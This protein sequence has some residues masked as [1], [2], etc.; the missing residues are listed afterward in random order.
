M[1]TRKILLA[2]L[3]L[4]GCQKTVSSPT[5]SVTS[6]SPD[7]V[8]NALSTAVV[9]SGASFDP[10]PVKTLAGAQDVRVPDASLVGAAT[11]DLTNEVWVASTTLQAT[12][13]VGA[14]PGTYD[15]RVTNP[16]GASGSGKALMLIVPPPTLRALSAVP[17]GIAPQSGHASVDVAVMISGQFFRPGIAVSLDTTKGATTTNTAQPTA[18]RV[19]SVSSD[20]TMINATVLTNTAPPGGPYDLIVKNN[21]GCSATLL[22]AYTSLAGGAVADFSINPPF[23]WDGEDTPVDITIGPGTLTPAGAQ[24]FAATP[25][26]EIDIR[27]PSDVPNMHMYVKL[28]RVAFLNDHALHALVPSKTTPIPDGIYDVRVTNPGG[29]SNTHVAAFRVVAEKVPTISTAE[30]SNRTTQDQ[31]DL[32]MCGDGFG[33]ES[34]PNAQA[35]TV[36][37]YATTDATKTPQA[38]TVTS[39]GSVT[40]LTY[41]GNNASATLVTNAAGVPGCTFGERQQL[42]IKGFLIGAT[43]EYALRLSKRFG[44]A[45]PTN[46]IYSDFLVLSVSSPSANPNNTVVGTSLATARR[47]LAVVEATTDLGSR[48][49]YAIGGDSYGDN[50]AY[51]VGHAPLASYEVAPI[52]PT[53]ALGAWT[54]LGTVGRPQGALGGATAVGRFAPAAVSAR[55]YNSS[56]KK[57]NTYVYV[58]GGDLGGGAPDAAIQR[59]LVLSER[60]T[61][62]LADPT[63]GGAGNLSA[64]TWYYKVSAI[65]P[66]SDPD[67]PDGETLPS[68]EAVV[69]IAPLTTAHTAQLSW[70]GIA[71]AVSYNIYRS[72]A[73]DAV[74]GSEVLIR[75]VSA[76]SA[77]CSGATPPVCQI[78]EPGAPPAASAQKPLPVGALGNFVDPTAGHTKPSARWG[79]RALAL[80]RSSDGLPQFYVLGGASAAPAVLGDIQSATAAE[81]GTLGDFVAGANALPTARFLFGA[82]IATTAT[83]PVL[84]TTNG[85]AENGP[86]I[87]ASFGATTVT[88]SAKTDDIDCIR[89]AASDGSFVTDIT[90]PSPGNWTAVW[91][92]STES[93]KGRIGHAA[94]TAGNQLVFVGGGQPASATVVTPIDLIN[95]IFFKVTPS[96]FGSLQASGGVTLSQ[97]R[98]LADAT[99]VGAN[100]YV[101][102]GRTGTVSGGDN[103]VLSSSDLIPLTR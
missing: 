34:A 51:T 17:P 5:P 73:A 74:S 66:G 11:W 6:I 8:C 57:L 90:A 87:C 4:V 25:T 83:S 32:V 70:T 52:D 96:F 29:S 58:F 38:F 92:T 28:R 81:D 98:F 84:T 54:E 31:T 100:I 59:A 24:A 71:S 47:G 102:G 12:V 97:P 72:A 16:L 26:V 85:G 56:S 42:T 14:A 69:S 65:L 86:V 18:L 36:T 78:D 21:E 39:A 46:D 41:A 64:G 44:D 91:T 101:V 35:V 30:S 76:G 79:H 63:L 33:S 103:R 95:S 13:P 68:D 23:G 61:P 7:V 80:T 40:S 60:N 82:A 75:N 9:I 48:E 43:G 10:L 49:L 53:G 3:C 88:A 62:R 19:D 45:D 55:I 50:A 67:N 99:T 93:N 27:Q 22:G 94:V 37:L 2:G 20:G 1:S 15:V 77:S 89:I